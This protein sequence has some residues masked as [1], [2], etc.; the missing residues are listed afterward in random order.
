MGHNEL[1][2]FLTGNKIELF[3]NSNNHYNIEVVQIYFQNGL[4]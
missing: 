4:W 1:Y 3:Y 2:K